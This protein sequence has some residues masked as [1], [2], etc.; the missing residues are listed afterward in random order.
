MASFGSITNDKNLPRYDFIDALRGIAIIGVLM[1]HTSSLGVPENDFL[2]TLI[3]G[4]QHGVYLFFVVSAFTIFNSIE[5]RQVAEGSKQSRNFFIRRFF[6]I[7]PLFWTVLLFAVPQVLGTASY[8]DP[9]GVSIWQIPLTLLFLHGWLPE[10]LNSILSVE[11]TLAVE[12]TFYLIVP[13][14][15]RTTRSI[16]AVLYLIVGSILINRVFNFI[17]LPLIKQKYP[18]QEYLVDI[19]LNR[20]FFAQLPIFGIGIL[21]FYIF[22][23]LSKYFSSQKNLGRA[24]LL[25]SGILYVGFLTG[26]TY[27]YLLSTGFLLSVAFAILTLAV[28]FYP[29]RIIVNSITIYIGKISYSLYLTHLFVIKFVSSYTYL[30]PFKESEGYWLK[31][32]IVLILSTGVSTVTYYLTHVTHSKSE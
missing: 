19:Y 17:L 16:H 12:M 14:L 15:T 26:H 32:L 28:F 7:A 6:R 27:L 30:L 24:L 18:G 5:R 10:T 29:S 4:G 2:S 13:F 25:V 23:S 31:F 20:W 3:F 21:M 1:V 22:K 11:W 9:N 8:Y